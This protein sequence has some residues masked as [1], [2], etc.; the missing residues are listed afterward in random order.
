MP[1]TLVLDGLTKR[2]GDTLAVD[3]LTARVRPGAVTGFL[4]PNGSGKTTTLRMLLGLVRPTA[5]SAETPRMLARL[6]AVPRGAAESS[7]AVDDVAAPSNAARASP[8]RRNPQVLRAVRS[9]NSSVRIRSVIRPAP[10]PSE[11]A[12]ALIGDPPL[13]R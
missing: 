7:P 6:S 10:A 1:T 8:P 2:F 5:G 4:G 9:L 12:M 3:G 11:R 13:P